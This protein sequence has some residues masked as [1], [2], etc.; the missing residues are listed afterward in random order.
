MIIRYLDP[1]GWG[2]VSKMVSTLI[3]VVSNNEHSYPNI[4]P[5]HQVQ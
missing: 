3:G 1:W 2:L 4:D 5:N